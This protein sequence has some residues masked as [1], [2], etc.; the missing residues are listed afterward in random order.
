LRRGQ[1]NKIAK[2]GQDCGKLPQR[3]RLQAGAAMQRQ[4]KRGGERGELDA[5]RYSPDCVG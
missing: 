4:A 3:G 2:L 5:M 1:G